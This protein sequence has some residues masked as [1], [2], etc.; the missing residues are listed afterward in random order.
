MEMRCQL[1]GISKAIQEIQLEIESAGRTDAKVLLTGESGVG[2]EVVA[3]LI[4]QASRRRL[5]SVRSD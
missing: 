3:H 2:K 1:V 4:H 5:R